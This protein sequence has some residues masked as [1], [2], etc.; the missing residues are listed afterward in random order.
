MDSLFTSEENFRS[1]FQEG[2]NDM[3]AAEELGAFILVLANASYDR[4]LFSEMK[5]VLKQRFDDWVEYFASA[6]FDES[7][8]AV[9]DVAVFRGLIELGFGNIRET[10]KRMAGIWQLQYNPM[11][12]LR[13]RRNADSKFDSNQLEYD[14]Q[15]FNFNKPFLKK[16]IFWE[17]DF[18]GK[19]LR[20]L[21]NKF[22]FADLHGL[23]VIEPDKEKPQW[24]TQQ[25]HEFVWQFLSETGAQMPIGM[26]YSSLGGYASVNHQHF[27]TFVS[28]KKYPVELSCWD[29]NGG[30]MP[31]PLS[32]RKHF[33]R[34]EAWQFIDALQQSNAAFNLLYRA[35]EVYCF[36]RAFQGSYP[37]AEWTPGFA[38]S[39][40]A[41]NMTVTLSKD[42]IKLEEADISRELHKIRR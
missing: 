1:A 28:K 8:Q 19:Q 42:F 39:E 15:L 14:A 21:Y 40:T 32:C 9:D 18:S 17:G 24:L 16:E 3:L 23:L 5:P 10:E 34:D 13:P 20:L 36:S 4:E 26:G 2:L 25:D 6:D 7:L 30:H 38:W 41:G 35:D 37:Q 12:A 11:R 29:H 22:P 27:Q 31:Y 33:K